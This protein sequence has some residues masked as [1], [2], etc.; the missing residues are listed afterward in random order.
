MLLFLSSLFQITFSSPKV[1]KIL[2]ICSDLDDVSFTHAIENILR[3]K[4]PFV[5]VKICYLNKGYDK[6]SEYR[7]RLSDVWFLRDFD[8]IWIFDFNPFWAYGNRLSDKEIYVLSKVVSE[9]RVLVIGYSTFIS[10]WSNSF[11]SFLG[12]KLLNYSTADT[13]LEFSYGNK[14]YKYNSSFGIFLIDVGEDETLAS[15]SNGWPAIVERDYGYGRVYVF[16]FNPV[17][18]ALDGRNLMAYNVVSEVLEASIEN[19]PKT[20]PPPMFEYFVHRVKLLLTNIVVSFLLVILMFS[21]VIALAR[22]GFLP[23]ALTVYMF[24]PGAYLTKRGLLKREEFRIVLDYI[25][26]HPGCNLREL[27]VATGFSKRELKYF[28]AILEG[29]DFITSIKLKDLDLI[30]CLKGEEGRAIVN[31]MDSMEAYEDII[32][33]VVKNPGVLL[34]ELA[35]KVDLDPYSLKNIISKL[36]N[37]GVLVLKKTLVDYR[38]YP[39]KK[40]VRELCE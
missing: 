37:Y 19:P 11:E 4:Y 3:Q 2:S 16:T 36:E 40:L 15:F 12:V 25:I 8:Q 26:M 32:I 34:T 7:S 6:A 20:V 23:Y 33:T 24:R 27:S 28:L 9:G 35:S 14:V 29:V 5:E 17:K 13:V 10:S 22:Y 39:T 18:W 1:V 21:S 38:I 31:V 30:F